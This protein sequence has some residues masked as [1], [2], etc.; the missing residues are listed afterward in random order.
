[1]I[2]MFIQGK[3]ER[4]DGLVHTCIGTKRDSVAMF[5]HSYRHRLDGHLRAQEQVEA[6]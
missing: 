2:A 4:L 6:R 5:I 1:M 3:R